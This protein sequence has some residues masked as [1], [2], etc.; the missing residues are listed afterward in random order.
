MVTTTAVAG[1]ANAHMQNLVLPSRPKV[2]PLEH[3]LA[4]RRLNLVIPLLREKALFGGIATALRFFERLAGEFEQARMIVLN[5]SPA[6]FDFEPWREW[7]LDVGNTAPRTIALLG[8]P[9]TSLS[10]C[11]EDFFIATFWTTA[12]FN[13]HVLSRQNQMFPRLDRRFV[14]LIQDYEPAFYPW[15]VP[16]TYAKSTYSRG[17]DVIAVFNTSLLAEFFRLQGWRF[18]EHHVFEPRLHPRLLEERLRQ[19]R[20]DKERLI[21]VYGRPSMPRNAFGAIVEGLRTWAETYPGARDWV[22]VSAGEPHEDIVLAK[23]IVLRSLGKLTLDDYALQLSRCW[24]GV[25]L[26][27]SPHPSYPPL[28]MAEF[29]AW[30]ITNKFENKDLAH[31]AANIVS[32]GDIASDSIAAR[33]A[34]C[35]DQFAPGKTA[36]IPGT[37]AVFAHQTDE[38]PFVSDLLRSW[39]ARG[40]G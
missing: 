29:G 11:R 12:I 37:P 17:N 10:L 8:N 16:H 18:S 40:E 39:G 19:G 25:S 32:L 35:C 31:H 4:G 22:L 9:E 13:R 20:R 27:L 3:S 5:Q 23:N 1:F 15:S 38:F 34:W 7:T 2:H 21:L 30:V 28:E 14:Y 24:V 6:D 36:A 26:M 33:V